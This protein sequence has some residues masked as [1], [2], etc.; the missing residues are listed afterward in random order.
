[1]SLALG[2]PGGANNILASTPGALQPYTTLGGQTIAAGSGSLSEVITA[3]AGSYTF[4]FNTTADTL[5]LTVSAVPLPAGFPLF[6]M[7]MLGLGMLGYYKSRTNS[8][9]V[10]A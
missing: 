6:A 3:P 10:A 4:S 8:H 5:H 7:A 9:A 2:N 1:M